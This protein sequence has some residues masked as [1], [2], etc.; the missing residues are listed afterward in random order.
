MER[1][2]DRDRERGDRNEKE[3]ERQREYSEKPSKSSESSSAKLR[4]SSSN[5][6]EERGSRTSAWTSKGISGSVTLTLSIQNGGGAGKFGKTIAVRKDNLKISAYE[7]AV[8]DGTSVKVYIVGLADLLQD[9]SKEYGVYEVKN[10][11]LHTQ[12]VFWT[13]IHTQVLLLA[14]SRRLQMGTKRWDQLKN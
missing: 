9:V 1:E 8:T 12:R 5:D 3:R 4:Q 7:S 10:N 14:L 13:N 11:S 2:R 6:Q